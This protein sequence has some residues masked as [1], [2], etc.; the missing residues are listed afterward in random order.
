MCI[1][2]LGTDVEHLF[3]AYLPFVYHLCE[4]SFMT[5]L[6]FKIGLLC[7]VLLL[8]IE[9]GSSLY[10]LLVSLL[11]LWFATIFSQSGVFLYILLTWQKIQF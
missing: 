3:M 7:L 1:S 6:H 8:T 9:F 5:L 11:D 4:L 2:L 10:T